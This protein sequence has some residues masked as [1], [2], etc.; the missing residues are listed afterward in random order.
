[1]CLFGVFFFSGVTALSTTCCSFLCSWPKL[2]SAS[3]K[4]SASLD[5]EYGK[6]Q[7]LKVHWKSCFFL[8]CLNFWL[9]I[10]NIEHDNKWHLIACSTAFYPNNFFFLSFSVE[11]LQKIISLEIFSLQAPINKA[12]VSVKQIS[13]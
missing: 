6:A 9:N 7:R 4:A 8:N 10:Q 5:G 1:M 3:S 2:A 13:L 11:F 12:L